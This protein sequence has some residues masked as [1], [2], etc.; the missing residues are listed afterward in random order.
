MAEILTFRR[1][2]DGPSLQGVS[3]AVTQGAL[4][5]LHS[6]KQE[7]SD[8]IVRLLL[9]LRRP[10]SGSVTVLGMD[11]AA[12]A[13]TELSQL[14]QRLAVVFSDG[15]LVSNLKVLENVLLPGYYHGRQPLPALAERGEELLR[16]VGYDGALMELP[17]NLSMYQRRLVGQARA[18]MTEPELIVYDGVLGGLNGEERGR[19]I[20]NAT[21]FHRAMPGMTTV[22]LATQPEALLGQGLDLSPVTEEKVTVCR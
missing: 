15:G 5:A 17:G 12:L 21:A 4:V 2:T 8:G 3:F 6:P 10:E 9:G 20:A 14:R 16:R 1:V 7:A 19:I 13:E 22:L 11:P 18:F